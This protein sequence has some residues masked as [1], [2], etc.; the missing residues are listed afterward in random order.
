M[1]NCH[2][3][4]FDY[5]SSSISELTAITV[6]KTGMLNR[7]E[8]ICIRNCD[9]FK[10]S[11][12]AA[13]AQIINCPTKH[14]SYWQQDKQALTHIKENKNMS[15]QSKQDEAAPTD[16]SVKSCVRLQQQN[17]GKKGPVH[18]VH[19]VSMDRKT[20]KSKLNA[21]MNYF[22]VIKSAVWQCLSSQL[23]HPYPHL[24][25]FSTSNHLVP[26]V[27]F[28]PFFARWSPALRTLWASVQLIVWFPSVNV[29]FQ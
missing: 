1:F 2:L 28:L 7:S 14:T 23:Q 12:T 26:K 16:L 13:K 29:L 25:V 22:L 5:R 8:M 18:S 24:Q 27:T 17:E 10:S 19:S 3:T 4:M 21:K 6:I 15:L 9:A 20:S 11:S